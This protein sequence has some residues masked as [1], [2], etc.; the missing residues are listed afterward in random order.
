MSA[1]IT[2]Y[3]PS[4]RIQSYTSKIKKAWRK[5]LD[6]ILEAGLILHEAH[7]KL[8][9]NSWQNLINHEL[10]FERRTA[11]K[12]LKISQ[13]VRLTDP[14]N[15]QYLPPRWTTLHELTYLSQKQFDA[16]VKKRQIHPA[17]E[18]KEAEKLTATNKRRKKAIKKREKKPVIDPNKGND[19]QELITKV[20]PEN[21]LAVIES[22]RE[23]SDREARDLENGLNELAEE[24]GFTFSYSGYSSVKA[25]REGTRNNLANAQ[26]RWLEDR[27]G[28]YNKR[29]EIL[30]ELGP[31]FALPGPVGETMTHDEINVLEEAIRQIE[32]GKYFRKTKDGFDPLDIRNPNNQY[33][34]WYLAKTD[35][36]VEWDP[37]EMYEYCDNN[38]IITKFTPLE[39]VDYQG[40]LRFLVY[41]HS[42][43]NKKRCV[44]VAKELQRLADREQEIHDL[45]TEANRRLAEGEDIDDVLEIIPAANATFRG[46]QMNKIVDLEPG[47]AN[48]ALKLLVQ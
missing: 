47:Y 10:P 14:N 20:N 18:R 26:R 1:S 7:E 13:D 17:M 9:P 19:D 48:A 27:K 11:E 28:H 3:K 16:A 30:R 36:N 23:L 31:S 46:P 45:E 12:L 4:R 22:G 21:Q 40:Y 33:H 43:G 2:P 38:Q 32:N 5:A 29:G 25:A 37:S 34:E 15:A 35:K 39:F 6:G 42:I 44:E 8:D 41:Q 24:F